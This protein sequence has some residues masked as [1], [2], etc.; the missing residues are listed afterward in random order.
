MNRL[1][2]IINLP[3]F[4]NAL[5][6]AID[7][8]KEREEPYFFIY[9]DKLSH[10]FQGINGKIENPMYAFIEYLRKNNEDVPNSFAKLQ[11]TIHIHYDNVLE[12]SLED[13]A[14]FDSIYVPFHVDRL[15]QPLH[16]IGRYNIVNSAF[17]FLILQQ[18]K[19]LEKNI[20]I[21]L[22]VEKNIVLSSVHRYTS[23]EEFGQ[24]LED[25]SDLQPKKFFERLKKF[26]RTNPAVLKEFKNDFQTDFTIFPEYSKAVLDSISSLG[27]YEI[28][29]ATVNNKRNNV[30]SLGIQ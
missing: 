4:T 6:P 28:N 19:R 30:Y 25:I 7:I 2:H 27:I 5:S 29:L 23:N 22:L 14:L 15:E 17:E 12:P 16:F 20:E 18:K 26:D 9:E 8:L 21:G 24:L 13:L 10:V 1:T 3:E 11:A